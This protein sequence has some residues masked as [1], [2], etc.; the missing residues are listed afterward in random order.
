MPPT[1]FC[2]Y[3]HHMLVLAIFYAPTPRGAYLSIT[4]LGCNIV[5]LESVLVIYRLTR[6]LI[7]FLCH[8][9][10]DLRQLLITVHDA[11]ESITPPG[12][13]VDPPNTPA[14]PPG[15]NPENWE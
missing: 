11:L 14:F 13:E 10:L 12:P 15:Q 9:T 6:P 8:A 5:K 2:L 1:V 3:S 7:H 4:I